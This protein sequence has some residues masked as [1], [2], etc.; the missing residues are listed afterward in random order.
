[1]YTYIYICL[2]IYIYIYIYIYIFIYLFI[3]TYIHTHIHTHEEL[4]SNTTTLAPL[5]LPRTRSLP[6]SRTT[7]LLLA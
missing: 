5:R 7:F 2:T 1:M 3:Y 4:L 6:S